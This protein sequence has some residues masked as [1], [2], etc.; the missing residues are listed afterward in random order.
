[1]NRLEKLLLEYDALVVND[2]A[3]R[4]AKLKQYNDEARAAAE[5][6]AKL[7]G[8]AERGK[9]SFT[10]YELTYAADSRCVCGAGL[11]YPDLISSRGAWYC[12]AI[13][14]GQAQPGTEH[15][16][17]FPFTFYEINSEGQPSAYGTTTRPQGTHIEVTPYYACGGCG[18]TGQGRTY[19]TEDD[20]ARQY[21]MR[22]L[23]CSQCGMQYQ[24]PNGS[25]NTGF[26]VRHFHRVVADN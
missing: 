2:A 6:V 20:K 7:I 3:G 16:P 24:N 9:G 1:M 12:S 17:A 21:S 22:E 26:I 15:S 10:V 4:D 13:L 11:A 19:R 8:Q 23:T 14:L 25:S 18:N 5:V